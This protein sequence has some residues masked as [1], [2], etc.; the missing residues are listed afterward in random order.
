[1][2][3][4]V[5]D[6]SRWQG[7]VD[8]G[9]MRGRGVAGVIIRATHGR[10][11]DILLAQHVAGARAGGYDDSDLGFYTFLNPKRGTPAE[12]AEATIDA[13][14]DA[15]G[16][17]DTFYM[18]DVEEYSAFSPRQGEAPVFGADFATWIRDHVRA[19]RA[20][21]PDIRIV[22]YT[23]AAF[24]DGPATG[25]PSGTRWVGDRTLAEEMEWIVPRYPIWPP[26]S[27]Q[28]DDSALSAWVDSSPKPPPPERW[29]DW[30]LDIQPAGPFPPS[31]V[32]WAGWQFSAG[33]NRQGRAYGASSDDLD[34][35]IIRT[36]A[37]QRWTRSTRQPPAPTPKP[38]PTPATTTTVRRGEGWIHIARRT[39]NNGN[40]WR[41]I[42]ALNGGPNRVIHP[43]D[44]ITLPK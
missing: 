37:W 30:A 35:N 8:F 40:R 15:L 38:K 36:E 9:V 19:V 33:Y 22:G 23:N 29:A 5:V 32:E 14:T 43:G 6:L 11:R 44:T 27:V 17:T 1:M 25:G 13:I 26:R 24:W 3:T 7:D 31:A 20:L 18:L 39:L 10:T 34:L 28:G 42:A 4:P 2:W 12:C 16:H 41:E 21:A